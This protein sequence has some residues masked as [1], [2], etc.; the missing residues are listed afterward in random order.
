ML[1]RRIVYFT[2]P[3]NNNV[4]QLFWACSERVWSEGGAGVQLKET[5]TRAFAIERL[6]IMR[7]KSG[8]EKWNEF[9][10]S[11]M[12]LPLDEPKRYR[13]SHI[14]D[15]VKPRP[16]HKYYQIWYALVV[17]YTKRK[18]TC[19]SDRLRAI[20]GLARAYHQ[21]GLM[22]SSYLYGLWR[23][24][25]E[26][27]LMW[28]GTKG[29]RRTEDSSHF[30][31]WSWASVEGSVFWF[32]N[33]SRPEFQWLSVEPSIAPKTGLPLDWHLTLKG[34]IMKTGKVPSDAKASAPFYLET[35]LANYNERIEKTS[36]MDDKAK[37]TEANVSF[38]LETTLVS[39][40]ERIVLFGSE[41]KSSYGIG[42]FGS[43]TDYK[44]WEL[45]FIVL[46]KALDEELYSRVGWCKVTYGFESTFF[47]YSQSVYDS[48]PMSFLWQ[49][50]V[51]TLV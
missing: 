10:G 32:P 13:V 45:Y 23:D 1:A 46:E 25:I 50:K 5:L 31:S 27:G 35:A 38:C 22:A 14:L 3:S 11:N 26:Y 48:C 39:R 47:N 29:A 49:E 2:S 17:E 24:D 6:S 51:I 37:Y 28:K 40:N 16:D 12:W 42:A 30:P 21:D 18:L 33:E 20:E 15:F 34:R 44:K 43:D 19:Q 9:G 7:E 36:E 8:E 41:Y 4:G